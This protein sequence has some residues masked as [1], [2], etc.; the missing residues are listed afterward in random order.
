VGKAV[1]VLAGEE[2]G[3]VLG[4]WLG[5]FDILSLELLDGVVVYIVAPFQNVGAIKSPN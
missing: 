3:E 5:R 4:F 1:G 2:V